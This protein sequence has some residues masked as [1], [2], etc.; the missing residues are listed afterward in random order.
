MSAATVETI[1]SRAISD[2]AFADQLFANPNQALAGFELTTEE[3]AAFKGMA[4]ADFETLL[5]SPE[6]RKSFL[7]YNMTGNPGIGKN[8]NQ[9]VLSVNN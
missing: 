5:A 7:S 2:S 8:H 1:L 6:E 3:V 4:R 9:T